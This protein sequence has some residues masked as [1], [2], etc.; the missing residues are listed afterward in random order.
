MMYDIS[1]GER[2]AKG[3]DMLVMMLG[4]MEENVELERWLTVHIGSKG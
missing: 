4:Y 3:S 2:D 1:A